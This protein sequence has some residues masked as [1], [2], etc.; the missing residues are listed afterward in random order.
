MDPLALMKGLEKVAHVLRVLGFHPLTRLGRILL[1]SLIYDLASDFDG[2]R[3]FGS[4]AHRG[5]LSYARAGQIE[6]FTSELFKT[7]VQRGLVVL[8]IGAHLGYYSLLAARAGARV[9]SFEPDPRAFRYLVRN[10]QANGLANCVV[11]VPKAVSDR[12]GR[13]ELF[14]DNNDAPAQNSLFLRTREAGRID[15]DTIRLDEF[16]DEAVVVDVIKMDIEGAELHALKGMERVIA[17]ASGRLTMFIECNGPCLRCAGHSA[18]QLIDWLR[19][20]GFSVMVVDE[21]D[22]RLSPPAVTSLDVG[23]VNLCCTRSEVCR[24]DA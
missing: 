6:P 1:T 8:D 9:F 21:Q 24:N 20:H 17:R 10:I 2:L 15:V 22:R 19:A 11:P 16:L 18:G 7:A 5:Y 13:A 4:V 23:S 14:L 3:M 12:T